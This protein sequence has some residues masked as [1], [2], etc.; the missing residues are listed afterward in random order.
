[1]SVDVFP[2]LDLPVIG[3]ASDIYSLGAILYEM[4]TGRPPFRAE[5]A[6]ETVHQLLT[7]DP[8]PP[9]RL[10]SKTPRD[11][12]IICLK[13]LSKESRRR[14]ATADALNDDLDRFLRGDAISARPE[15]RTRRKGHPPQAYSRCWSRGDGAVRCIL[16]GWRIVAAL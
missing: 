8:V 5:C 9:S 3:P 14:Y 16:P 4:M 11:L 13:C 12:E 6:A 15:S 2:K 1:M 10:N 7:Q